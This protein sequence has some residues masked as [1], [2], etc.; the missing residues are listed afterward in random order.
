MML[1]NSRFQEPRLWDGC[2]W[3]VID[4]NHDETAAVLMQVIA[5]MSP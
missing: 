4:G 2:P 3:E 1:L 5:K